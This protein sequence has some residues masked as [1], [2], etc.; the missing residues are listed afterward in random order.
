MREG[1]FFERRVFF[2][3]RPADPPLSFFYQRRT[4]F[5]ADRRRD[6]CMRSFIVLFFTLVEALF[7]LI[8]YTVSSFLFEAGRGRPCGCLFF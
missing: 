6:G 3:N 7:R 2:L 1:F 4:L 5:A 8:G